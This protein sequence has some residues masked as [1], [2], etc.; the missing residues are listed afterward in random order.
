MTTNRNS[1]KNQQHYKTLQILHCKTYILNTTRNINFSNF[2]LLFGI[3]VLAGLIPQNRRLD[4]PVLFIVG[5]RRLN[6]TVIK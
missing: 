5:R 3:H 1:I 4:P 6:A 2:S